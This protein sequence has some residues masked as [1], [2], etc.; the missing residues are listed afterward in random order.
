MQAPQP[1]QFS[2]IL[3]G[4]RLKKDSTL[5]LNIGTQELQPE[6]TAK[7]FELG[8]KQL[9][10]ALAET[11]IKEDQLNIPESMSEFKTD[12][13]PSQRLRNVFYVYWN[14][15]KK[16]TIDWDSYYKREIEKIIDYIKERL[17]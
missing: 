5:S 2:A 8:N 3:D 7:I 10:V 14:D 17:D 13:T 6:D 1:I 9:W 12:K 4:V 16:G 11:E 15:K